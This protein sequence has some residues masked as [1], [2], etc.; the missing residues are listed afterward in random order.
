MDN[1]S[2]S[3]HHSDACVHVRET[4]GFIASSG[5]PPLLSDDEVEAELTEL[6]RL[7]V[8]DSRTFADEYAAKIMCRAFPML[9]PYG[10][11][12]LF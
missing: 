7:L 11:L 9:F 10:R 1:H 3:N 12:V 5:P 2:N 4:S 8:S 6:R